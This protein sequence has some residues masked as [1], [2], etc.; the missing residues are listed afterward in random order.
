MNGV[1]HK[2]IYHS[3]LNSTSKLFRACT[4]PLRLK[5]IAYI[6]EHRSI[7]VNRIYD[8]L[9]LKQSVTSQHLKILRD[10]QLVVT[11][12]NGKYIFYSLN[13]RLL[14]QIADCTQKYF[15]S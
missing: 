2:L 5:L 4:H 6:N 7:N 14:E 3:N 15:A 9:K 10:A 1:A 13:Y 8:S 11:Q 12:R